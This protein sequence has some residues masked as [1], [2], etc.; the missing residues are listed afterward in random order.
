MRYLQ[1]SSK[2]RQLGPPLLSAILFWMAFF[3]VNW[4][5]LGWLAFVP[6]LVGIAGQ[7]SKQRLYSSLIFGLCFYGLALNWMRVA[8]IRMVA[9]WAMLAVWAGLFTVILGWVVGKIYDRHPKG[10]MVLAFPMVIV[11]IE[12]MRAYALEGFPWYFLGHTQHDTLPLLQLAELGG[13]Y[14]ITLLVALVNGIFAD[15]WLGEK[16]ECLLSFPLHRKAMGVGL[17][18]TGALWFGYSRL[19]PTEFNEGTEIAVL[20]ADHPQGI[21]NSAGAEQV[22][23]EYQE[24]IRTLFQSHLRP[25]VLVW[26]E[27]SYPALVDITDLDNSKWLP[28]KEKPNGPSQLLGASTIVEPKGE[29]SKQFNSAV[30]FDP[31]GIPIDHYDK[32]HRVPFGEYV[33]LKDWIPFINVLAP[34]DHD[35]SIAPGER[36][37]RF[38]LPYSPIPLV[39]GA[40]ICYESGDSHHFRSLA[41]G[42]GKP[43]VDFFINQS[44]D[45]WFHG[46]EEH[47]HHLLLLR[48]RAVETR[49]PVIRAVN[50][51]I[52]A[53]VDAYGRVLRPKEISGSPNEK[54]ARIFTIT[55]EELPT[56][57]WGKFKQNTVVLVGPVPKRVN[58]IPMGWA[59][60]Q[61]SWPGFFALGCVALIVFGGKQKA[62]D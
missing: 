12:W 34:Y 22:R 57:E 49:R 52:S 43:P 30:L 28:E 39:F 16:P 6:W 51:G 42:D 4:P 5:W 7:S 56:G 2:L 26:P 55:T 23:V 19:G 37:T 17:A 21:R 35:Y 44:N 11:P 54:T 47:E 40:A 8:D 60:L 10:G 20:Q 13:A 32:I 25:L 61:G 45:G 18:V 41:G 46:T 59:R 31:K 29:P 48:F 24:M 33:P 14:L 38:S 9:T 53:W 58:G 27:T 3:P 62:R 50:M 1:A 15:L 36:L